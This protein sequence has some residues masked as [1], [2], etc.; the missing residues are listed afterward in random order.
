MQLIFIR[1]VKHLIPHKFEIALKLYFFLTDGF[2][3]DFGLLPATKWL[4]GWWLFW[5]KILDLFWASFF[6]AVFFCIFCKPKPKNSL[7]FGGQATHSQTS[8]WLVAAQ[9]HRDQN[10]FSS[11][12]FIESHKMPAKQSISKK[13]LFT[14]NHVFRCVQKSRIEFLPLVN[15]EGRLE[16]NAKIRKKLRHEFLPSRI[17]PVTECFLG[18]GSSK[19]NSI[20]RHVFPVFR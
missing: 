1:E 8:H 2:K 19:I 11:K 10:F 15:S 14:S 4:L 18:R 16:K 12:I 17:L 6:L 9:A 3:A 7:H 13:I 5:A 20:C